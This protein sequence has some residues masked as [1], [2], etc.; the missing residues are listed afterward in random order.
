MFKRLQEFKHEYGHCNVPQGFTTDLELATWV[1]NQR[2]AYRYMLDNKSKDKKPTKRISPDRV[3][4]LNHLGFEWR[5]Y[6]RAD[7]WADHYFGK[8]TTTP[9]QKM[10]TGSRG[11]QHAVVLP[12]LSAAGPL[13][14][15]V[16]SSPS[17]VLVQPMV[18]GAAQPQ[19]YETPS[20]DVN[21]RIPA[22]LLCEET[23]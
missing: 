2:Q 20:Q 16:P 3:T 23:L 8:R 18:V 11:K 12:L 1:K 19:P 17:V 5:K 13:A 4:R 21:H 10:A 22:E 7:D 15:A 9:R 14:A 6:V